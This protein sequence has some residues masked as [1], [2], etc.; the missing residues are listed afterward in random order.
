M[1]KAAFWHFGLGWGEELAEVVL[2][3]WGN[4]LPGEDYNI[5]LGAV[6][7]RQGGRRII[8]LTVICLLL[9]HMSF[10]VTPFK[11]AALS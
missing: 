9:K 1:Q 11:R 5:I 4:A 10:L 3:L 6:K 8:M 7:V 2:R